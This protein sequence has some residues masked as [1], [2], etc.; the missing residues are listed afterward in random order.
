MQQRPRVRIQ[1]MSDLHLE[2]L[3]DYAT[4]T[5]PKTAPHLLLAGDIG[6]LSRYTEFS[7]FL[8]RQCS[9]YDHVFLV[10]GNHEFFAMTRQDALAA[11]SSLAAEPKMGGRLTILHRTR[12]DLS[13]TVTLLGCTLQSNVPEESKEIVRQKL[14]DFRQINGWSVDEHNQE[15]EKDVQWLQDEIESINDNEPERTIIVATH[16]APTHHLTSKPEYA[17]NA[18]RFGFA[19][20]L[21]ER[22]VRHWRGFD[23][24]H[25][26]VFGHTHWNTAFK[27]QHMHVKANQRGYPLGAA[28]IAGSK[29][30]AFDD[31]ACLVVK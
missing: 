28:G 7:D 16:H 12:V 8:Q 5:F 31:R 21:L 22:R 9:V 19:T 18:W 30:K 3:G 27:F 23:A 6:R 11:A 26:W 29:N 17:N 4:F 20:D 24:V 2:V 15:H 10:L 14:A 13:S 1:F 25:T